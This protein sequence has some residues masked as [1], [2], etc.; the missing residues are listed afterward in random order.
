MKFINLTKSTLIGL[1]CS[2]AIT[3]F[4]NGY[5]T[6]QSGM[7]PVPDAAFDTLQQI[8][9]SI[10]VKEL[11]K[12]LT[13][14]SAD[15]MEGR[16]LGTE[17]N[18]KAARYIAS[19]FSNMGIPELNGDGYFQA[20][21][22]YSA[23]WKDL[24]LEVNGKKYKSIK[25]FYSILSMNNS[26]DRFETDEVT[27][28]GYGIDDPTYSD[29]KGAD[30]A[31]KVILIYRGEPKDADGNSLITKSTELSSWSRAIIRKL[32]TARDKGVK[33]VLVIDDEY[34]KNVG[35]L[36]NRLIGG[37][38][39]LGEPGE[40]KT[41]NYANQL[42]INTQV[43]SDIL[44][45]KKK[46]VIK[47]RDKIAKKGKSKPVSIPTSIAITQVKDNVPVQ[48]ENVLAYIEGS[49]PE[50][51]DELVIITAHYDHV[52]QRGED[53]FNG[54]DD[55]GSGTV[56]V[57]EIAEAFQKAK[58]MGF[59]SKRSVLC[60][61]VTGEEK[62]L[63]GSK[64]YTDNPI[65]PLE[66]TVV[67]INI[68]MVGRVDEKHASNPDYIYVI[69]SDMMSDELHEINERNNSKYTKLELDYTYNAVDDPNRFFYR[70]DHF[71]FAIKGIPAI[72][73]FNG[74]H[75]DYHRPSDTIEKINFEVMRKRALL[76]FYNAWEIAN[77]DKPISVDRLIKQ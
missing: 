12:H 29:Y 7:G 75:A 4:F 51:K 1:L 41:V 46:K 25:E 27:F 39:R 74:T 45:K 30:V 17:A 35:E 73:Y 65:F 10:T 71:N 24:S 59:G 47:T 32:R 31:G 5:A 57:L 61:L 6:A 28:L 49:D 9:N 53:V 37:S 40:L 48:H 69:G 14:L 33:A 64:Y 42:F 55:D 13:I 62:G 18:R 60:M 66:K 54:A 38:V 52:G 23:Q 19:A 36:R 3:V 11:T 16:E 50:L 43:L 72:F 2:L 63:L 22:F 68:D 77:R 26:K 15:D 76:A 20:I 58:E 67:N 44:G 56:T 8:A 21:P 70:S 34:T